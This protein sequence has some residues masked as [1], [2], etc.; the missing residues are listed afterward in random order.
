[1]SLTGAMYI[2]QSGLAAAQIGLQI[3]GNNIANASTPG[4]S[5]QVGIL[6]P[7]RGDSSLPGMNVGRGVLMKDIRR[8]VDDALQQRLWGASSDESAAQAY[9]SILS[10]VESALGELGSNDLSSEMSA[11]FRTWSERANQT[12]ANGTVVQQGQKLADFLH[13]LRSDLLG[14]RQSLDAGLGAQVERANQLIQ[15]IADLNGAIADA[16]VTGGTASSLRDQRDQAIT[17]LSQLMDVH[18]VEQSRQGVDVLVG[19]I[20]VVSAGTP[21]PIELRR[22]VENGQVS[23]K[24]VV[25]RDA[26]E[27]DVSSGQIGAALSGR[28]DVIDSVLA[29]L[30]SVAGQLAFEVNKLHATGTNLQGL[31]TTTGGVPLTLAER[32]LA[33]NDP[34]NRSIANLPYSAANGSFDVIVRER[35]TGATHTIRVRVDLDGVDNTG[36]PGTSNDTSADAIRAALDAVDGIAAAFTPDG[37]LQVNADA[38]FDFS[39]ANDSSGA[40]AVLGLNSF[41]TGTDA[42]SLQ[43]R[44]D[45]LGDPSLLTTGRMVDGQFVENGTALQ[46]AQLQDQS[47]A[48][49]GGRTISGMWQDAAQGVGVQVAGAKTAFSAATTVR[50]SLDTQRGSISGVSIDEESVNLLNFQRMYQASAKVI[51]VA[52]QMTQTLIQL[53]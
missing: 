17:D 31:T 24:V 52:D 10:Q 1:M 9:Q 15:S 14:Q 42:G 32:T 41:F 28:T 40:V 39:F 27:L 43:V 16:E 53:V 3:A 18:V 48:A 46:I 13:R 2:G 29:T 7:I 38:G 21:H 8:Q 50:Q 49:L 51:S 47:L 35:A 33:L 11:F 26:Q 19:S 37:K 20:P 22:T 12:Q 44:S 25:S 34:D 23:A 5:R 36:Q 6:S 4:Y 30:D 45:L